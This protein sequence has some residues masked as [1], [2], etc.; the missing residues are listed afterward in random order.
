MLAFLLVLVGG[1]ELPAFFSDHM[2]LQRETRA[3]LWGR[4][5]PNEHIEVRASWD[6]AHALSATADAAG[7]WKVQLA[8]PAAGG[9]YEIRL[10]SSAGER[11][12]RDVL[13]GELW[14]ASGQSNMEWTLGPRVGN[15]VEGWE[16]VVGNA[17]D[18]LLRL[19]DVENAL[20][21]A[22]QSDL[23][24]SWRVADAESAGTFSACAYFFARKLRAELG[25]PVGVISSDWGGTPVE[26][27][28]R[29]SALRPYAEF[30]EAL[31]LETS[32]AKDP[33]AA[34]RG[35]EERTQSYWKHAD[36]L[37]S[38]LGLAN[39]SQPAFDD[40]A[41]V[42][43][44]LPAPFEQHGL[45]DFDG[46]VWYRNSINVPADWAGQPL[47]LELGA[48]DDRDTV[49]WN[50]ERIGG[51]EQDGEWQTPRRYTI[52]GEQVRAGMHSLVIRVLDTGGQGG[53][54][55]GVADFKLQPEQ[56]EGT[57][58]LAGQWR[59]KAG[60]PMAKLGWP[61][62]REPFGPGSPSVLWNAMVAPLVPCAL[63]GAIWYQGESNIGN[64]QQYATLFPAMIRDWRAAFGQG[65]FPFY[66]VQIA[67]F[68]YGGDTGQA[69]H[70][71]DVQRR[72]LAVSNTGMAVTMD[73][74][75]PAD[76]HPLKKREVGERLAAWALAQTYARGGEYSGPLFR[77]AKPERGALH[78]EFGHAAGLSSRGAPVRHLLLAGADR[79]FHPAEGRIE[80]E[81]LIVSCGEVKEPVAVR[82]GWGAADETNLWNGAGFPAAS[83]RSDDWP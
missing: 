76:I 67:P 79:V 49:Y 47:R 37:D 25:V 12:L 34:E 36:E 80:G 19:F 74:G 14:L 27:W 60:A 29:A 54:S 4:A 68:D 64:A 63:R 40:S 81:A 10:T 73:I 39:A 77:A 75:N 28:T 83:F 61:P 32:F 16:E 42:E 6:A 78:V 71:R 20:T 8:T 23:K 41:W 65:D 13:V 59:C 50:G 18:P 38:S 56:Q 7:D 82:L 66:F 21:P 3:P 2:V 62:A 53:F 5:A 15:G 55:S 44:L 48:I 43:V 70:L 30:A 35:F 57:M 58:V 11:V 1:P 24:G 9:P 69:A 31:A 33:A 26:A 17:G 22:P 46:L 45:A 51:L 72:T 52:P